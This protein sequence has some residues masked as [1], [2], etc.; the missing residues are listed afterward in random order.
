MLT[1]A[2]AS[3]ACALERQ[4]RLEESAAL[5]TRALLEQD[6]EVRAAAGIGTRIVAYSLF[7]D[8][9]EYCETAVLNAQA[10]PSVYPGWQMRVFHDAS[11][12][13][14][15][16]QRLRAAG[17][18]TIAAAGLGIAHWPGT[19]WRFAAVLD[20]RAEKVLFRDADSLVGVRERALVDQWLAS[21]RPFHVV[22]DWYSHVDLML[23]GLWAAHAP[24]LAGMRAWVEE[25]LARG[26]LHPTHADQHFLAEMVWPRIADYTL[27]QD[28]VH[29]IPGALPIDSDWPGQHASDALGGFKLKRYEA[30]F[31]PGVTRYQLLVLDAAGQVVCAYDRLARDG[32]DSFE[33]P[34]LYHDRFAS[35]QWRLLY[36]VPG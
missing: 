36:R 30:S 31:P 32:A 6:R 19:F 27:V 24:L 26:P 28:K 12:P 22:R 20:P 11:V 8:G 18:E 13:G 3:E 25:Y 4:G 21:G 17:A 15:V 1:N 29:R 14:A 2:D 33:L 5:G 34:T 7:G 16:L 35:G 10:M 9:P 23:A